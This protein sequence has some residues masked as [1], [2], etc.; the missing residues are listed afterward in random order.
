MSIAE[1]DAASV[2]RA[3]LIPNWS[4]LMVIFAVPGECG[5]R[6]SSIQ[7]DDVAQT[8]NADS[9]QYTRRWHLAVEVS[10]EQIRRPAPLARR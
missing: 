6:S 5:P 10:N 9:P 3:G 8:C 4:C 7:H 1:S 2:W